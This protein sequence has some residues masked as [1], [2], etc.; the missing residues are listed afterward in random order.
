[1]RKIFI[2]TLSLCFIS[3]GL[4]NANGKDEHPPL[5]K[6]FFEIG[7]K[8]V[9]KAL[10]ECENHFNKNIEL[11]YKMPPIEFTHYFGRCSKD[12]GINNNFEIEYL[13]ENLSENHYQV[14]VRPREHRIKFK[15]RNIAR[16]IK[17]DK[18]SAL[19]LNNPNGVNI[20]V[21]ERDDWQYMLSVDKRVSERV[22]VEVLV[23][24]ANSFK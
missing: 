13:N 18:G 11:P 9:E 16:K 5:E 6:G 2:L 19:L 15:Q 8:T 12:F 7:Y 3:F 17:M 10:D 14:T 23:D 22:P 24:I 20:L 21:F 1:M 4:V